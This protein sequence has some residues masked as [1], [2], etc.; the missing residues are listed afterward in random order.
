MQITSQI[1]HAFYLVLEKIIRW[2]IHPKFRAKILKIFG[3]NIGKNVRIYEVQLINLKEGFKNLHI[4]DDVHI[5]AGCILDL[6]GHVYIG[7][8]ST[9]SPRVIIL[10]HQDPGS[11]H[12]SKLLSIYKPSTGKVYIGSDCWIGA[13]TTII[14]EVCLGNCVVVGAGS[15]VTRNFNESSMIAGTPASLIKKLNI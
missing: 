5:G 7:E 6:E 2:S 8:R 13:N 3:A 4:A 1:C 14:S 12:M 10:T 9:L 15:V 11:S